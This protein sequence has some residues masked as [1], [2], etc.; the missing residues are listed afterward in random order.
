VQ[1]DLINLKPGTHTPQRWEQ[2]LVVE[3][4]YWKQQLA[5]KY[6]RL[7]GKGDVRALQD[8]LG[9]HPEFLNKRGSHNRTLL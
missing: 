4:G 2:P 6:L 9:A 1:E 8:L 7:A 5:T 3:P